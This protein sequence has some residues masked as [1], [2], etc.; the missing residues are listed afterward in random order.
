MYRDLRILFVFFLSVRFWTDY[1]LQNPRPCD[2]L[3]SLTDD[4]AVG[5]KGTASWLLGCHA[6]HFHQNSKEIAL[7]L[8]S[9]FPLR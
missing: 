6:V 8:P 7:K 4:L 2:Y 1:S 3:Y 5:M 9:L